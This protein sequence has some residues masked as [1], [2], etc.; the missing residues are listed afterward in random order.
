VID[1]RL[2]IFQGVAVTTVELLDPIDQTAQ[3]ALDRLLVD[4]RER[5]CRRSTESLIV[6]C[7]PTRFRSHG[8]FP[9]EGACTAGRNGW[10]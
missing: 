3:K 5:R 1:L 7:L 4:T 9:G 6:S 8:R 2:E 10:K